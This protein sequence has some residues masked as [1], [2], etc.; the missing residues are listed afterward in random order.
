[1]IINGM[2]QDVLADFN[3]MKNKRVWFVDYF[4]K[5]RGHHKW[6]GV[7]FFVCEFLYLVIA[8]IPV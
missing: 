3:E 7:T 5:Y 8:T 6:Y 1:M 2:N 4:V